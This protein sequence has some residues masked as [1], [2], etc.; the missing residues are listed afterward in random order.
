M[1]RDL[2]LALRVLRRISWLD[3][4]GL[5]FFAVYIVYKILEAFKIKPPASGFVTF[6][7]VVAAVYFFFRLLPFIRK[8]LLWRLRNRLIVA[9]LF[10]AVVPVI[11]L[12][13]M[14][15]ISLYMLYAQLGAHL[16]H[17]AVQE[18]TKQME[19]ASRAITAA[20]E[21]EASRASSTAAS[22]PQKILQRPEVVA[23]LAGEE[24]DLPG[25]T[26]EVE[27]SDR[28]IP[29]DP[30][31]ERGRRLFTGLVDANGTLWLRTVSM[32]R[33][34]HK[35][36]P[37]ALSIP[38]DSAGLDALNS[39]LGPIQLTVMQPDFS[40]G[41][42][43]HFTLDL[44]GHKWA[45]AREI[46]SHNRSL[47]EASSF[48]DPPLTGGLTLEAYRVEPSKPDAEKE[49]VF[50]AFSV[51]PSR[52]NQRLFASVGELGPLLTF[53]LEASGIAFI[54]I[55]LGALVTGVVLTYRITSAVGDL[56]DAT[57]FV[58]RAD[59]THRIRVTKRDQ[60]G[61]L[62]DSF[63][64]MTSS[65]SGLLEEQRKRQR[66]E[67]EIA[68]AREVQSQLF[69]Q[70]IPQIE[71][72]QL[73]AICRPARTVSGDYYDFIPLGPNRVGIALAD[74]SGKG[75]SAA[76]LM[77]SVQAALR[78]HALIGGGTAELVS[79]VN[80]HLF[81]NT[82]DDRYATLFYA[83]YDSTTQVLEYTNAGHCAPVFIDGDKVLKLE[84]GG[85]VVGLFDE[86]TYTAETIR[87]EANSLLVAY[88]DGLSEP[89][90]AYGE[91]YGT[92]RLAAEVVR[93]QTERV[94]QLAERLIDSSA[95]WNSGPLQAD[96]MTVLVA[97][98]HMLGRTYSTVSTSTN[99][100]QIE[101]A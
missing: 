8:R 81:H 39:E 53:V 22:D 67:N 51:R 86:A 4:I 23:V 85:T 21:D 32:V 70:T 89:E 38:L 55:E 60:L 62:G 26:A 25:L 54:L 40:T 63:N 31:G 94:Q 52:L 3:R 6:L 100:Q 27:P 74:I 97:R 14:A 72:L 75:I 101:T 59:F 91:E 33:A 29:Q 45:F 79:R 56:Y 87:A 35:P 18:R 92:A 20:A 15:T 78:S 73:T 47:G 58:R 84:T 43:S 68:I 77:A 7:F 90:N 95:Q 99:S 57:Q 1:P 17:D 24:N 37:I 50:A 69:P 28:L 98:F 10:I 61:V 44:Y 82:S 5:A 64:E 93:H 80:Q 13:T 30:N 34:P 9:Y 41:P 42:A 83:I 71:G 16:L 12:L 65:I 11:L 48:L 66:L 36:F 76:L 88:S 2:K 19:S 49:P 96:D 46:R